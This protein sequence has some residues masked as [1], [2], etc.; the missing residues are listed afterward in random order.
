M[1]HGAHRQNNIHLGNIILSFAV[2]FARLL[3]LSVAILVGCLP[4]RVGA[5]DLHVFA[6]ASL[7]DALATL[8]VKYQAETEITVRIS[9]ASSSTL[10]RQIDLGAPAE[11][12]ISANEKWMDYLE[13]HARIKVDTRHDIIGNTLVL[14]TPATSTVTLDIT[15]KTE[16]RSGLGDAR[17]AMGDPAHVP[18]GLYGKSALETL[19][20]WEDIGARVARAD[21]ARAA[22][23]LVAR[24]ETPLGI[25]YRSDALAEPNVRIVGEFPSSS[26]PPI[27][28]PA[29]V[30][31]ENAT[32]AAYAWLKFLRST[33]AR[34]VFERQG[35]TPLQ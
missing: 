23:A 24:G 25:V 6:A 33:A 26:H 8:A 11:V 7:S 29:A 4:Y 22:L 35:F 28:Y 1:L 30:V 19:G 18:I 10:A 17:L 16:F 14:I 15:S 31:A 27:V 5:N 3:S 2:H 21:N 13:A 20:I 34:R 12:F 9:L 32:P